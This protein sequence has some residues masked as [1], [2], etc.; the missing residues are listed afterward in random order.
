MML[1][2]LIMKIIYSSFFY[3]P[4]LLHNSLTKLST[5]GKNQSILLTIT[6][7]NQEHKFLQKQYDKNVFLRRFF[8]FYIPPRFPSMRTH[9][10]VFYRKSNY[11]F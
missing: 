3:P 9:S 1:L 7:K 8:R 4:R 10:Q 2:L 6:S 5:N 11:T